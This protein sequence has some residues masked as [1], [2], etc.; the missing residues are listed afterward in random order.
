MSRVLNIKPF[1]IIE[2]IC[3][4][5]MF[6]YELYKIRVEKL[7]VSLISLKLK[8]ITEQS[9]LPLQFVIEIHQVRRDVLNYN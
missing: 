6:S 5:G 3:V 8:T 7:E 4:G 1:L 9:P 2:T